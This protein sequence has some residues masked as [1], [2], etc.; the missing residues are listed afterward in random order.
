[1]PKARCKL[2]ML[3]AVAG[4]LIPLA[5][6][7]VAATLASGWWS[8]WDNA[9]SDLGNPRYDPVTAIVFN[10]ALYTGAVLITVYAVLCIPRAGGLEAVLLALVGFTLGLV[11]VFDETYG[12][13]HFVASAAFFL[14]MIPYVIAYSAKRSPKLLATAAL[15]TASTSLLWYMHL[16]RDTPPGAAPPELTSIILLLAFYTLH[17]REVLGGCGGAG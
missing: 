4:P 12:H 1:M 8:F 6:I 2:C 16:V 3:L 7:A 13:A 5:G 11:A 17:A 14:A 15:G 9:F 10:S